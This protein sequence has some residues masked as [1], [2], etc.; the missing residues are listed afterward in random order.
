MKLVWSWLGEHVDLGGV[1]PEEVAE[2][3]TVAGLEV[4]KVERIGADWDRE[5]FRSHP[6]A[7]T[8][9]ARNVGL[10]ALALV[11]LIAPP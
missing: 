9:V 5:R 4:D 2:R 11:I 7:W 6:L 1:T 8:D 3:L 10:G